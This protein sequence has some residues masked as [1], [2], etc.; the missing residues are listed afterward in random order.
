MEATK[1]A[2]GSWLQAIMAI[3]GVSQWL[4]ERSLSFSIYN[5]TLLI[6]KL[7]SLKKKK[8]RRRRKKK[9]KKS[10]KDRNRYLYEMLVLQEVTLL[11]TTQQRWPSDKARP[12]DRV[13]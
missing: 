7:T 10:N 4:E 3:L 1:E 11:T 6:K 2:P 5:S 12:S 13:V 9:G 8:K